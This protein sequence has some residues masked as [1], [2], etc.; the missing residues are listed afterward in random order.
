MCAFFGKV[1]DVSTPIRLIQKRSAQSLG[2]WHPPEDDRVLTAGEWLLVQAGREVSWDAV[3]D[4][5]KLD[6]D[7]DATSLRIFDALQPSQ[8]IVLL[9]AVLAP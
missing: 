8:E 5:K 3:E 2:A 7:Q 9:A 6:G 4:E 1:G